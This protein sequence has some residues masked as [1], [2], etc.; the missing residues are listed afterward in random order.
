MA[1]DELKG[2]STAIL[3]RPCCMVLTSVTN[4]SSCVISWETTSSTSFCPAPM[5]FAMRCTGCCQQPRP[6]QIAFTQFWRTNGK[7]V[8]A[9]LCADAGHE[10]AG[11]C[12]GKP[13]RAQLCQQ[14]T[15][16]EVA[17]HPSMGSRCQSASLQADF[18]GLSCPSNRY[19]NRLAPWARLGLC[20]TLGCHG[21]AGLPVPKYAGVRC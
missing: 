8:A 2:C 20:V 10:Q 14:P 12:P 1:P 3:A 21:Q 18:S 11:C 16:C 15:P 7:A 17:V 5:C 4:V 13:F 9:V 6:T 19:D